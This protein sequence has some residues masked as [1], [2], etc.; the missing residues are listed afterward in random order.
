MD[1]IRKKILGSI[2]TFHQFLCDILVG[3]PFIVD[4]RSDLFKF[5]GAV[6]P[7]RPES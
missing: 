4:N 1:V 3:Q 6:S 7:R 5:E 2:C